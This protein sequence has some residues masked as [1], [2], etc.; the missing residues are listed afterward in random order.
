MFESK[1]MKVL[2]EHEKEYRRAYAFL[3]TARRGYD[4]IIGWLYCG[5]EPVQSTLRHAQAAAH[6]AGATLA[7]VEV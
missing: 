5:G 6:Q 7:I 3:P 4:D 2:R 1:A